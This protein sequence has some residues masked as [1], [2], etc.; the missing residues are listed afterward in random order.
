[1][2]KPQPG[3]SDHSCRAVPIYGNDGKP[4]SILTISKSII[5]SRLWPPVPPL[6]FVPRLE[7]CKLER[8]EGLKVDV[9][10][11]FL[12]ASGS[13]PLPAVLTAPIRLDVVQQVHS[14]DI[15]HQR[16]RRGT[17]DTLQRVLPK[18]GDSHT[19]SAKKLVT[20]RP[21]NLGVPAVQ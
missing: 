6:A 11:W 12:E 10:L 15:F 21:P 9:V 14:T 20:K 18:T 7:V 2:V 1:M 16:H 13:L 4:S 3:D 17:N 8:S 19:L 5:P